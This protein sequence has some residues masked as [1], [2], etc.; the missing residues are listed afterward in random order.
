MTDSMDIKQE[1]TCQHCGNIDVFN[2]WMV[3]GYGFTP[4]FCSKCNKVSSCWTAARGS[5]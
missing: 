2:A 1:R 4:T 5:K 3:D